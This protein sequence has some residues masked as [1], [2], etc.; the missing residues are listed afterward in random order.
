MSWIRWGSPC[1]FTIPIGLYQ[2]DVDCVENGCPGSDLYIYESDDGFHCCACR[3]SPGDVIDS[4]DYIAKTAEQMENHIM[5]HIAAGH[6]TRQSLRKDREPTIAARYKGGF[7]DPA[8]WAT[9][10]ASEEQKK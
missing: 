7:F 9:V 2:V 8:T 6:H 3:F 1:D 5:E 10:Q 4:Q